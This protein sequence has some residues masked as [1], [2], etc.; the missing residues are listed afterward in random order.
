MAV[1]AVRRL[2]NLLAFI[3][4]NSTPMVTGGTPVL[5]RMHIYEINQ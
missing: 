4:H 5:V 3:E 1:P 2:I